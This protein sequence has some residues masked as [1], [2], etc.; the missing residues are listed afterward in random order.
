MYV[1]REGKAFFSHDTTIV[2]TSSLGGGE[3]CLLACFLSFPLL[4][5][6]RLLLLLGRRRV[7]SLTTDW[8]RSTCLSDSNSGRRE[9]NIHCIGSWRETRETRELTT[10]QSFLLLKTSN[11]SRKRKKEWE[12][13]EEEKEEATCSF[14]AFFLSLYVCLSISCV[15]CSGSKWG[16][17]K[18]EKRGFPIFPLMI[19]TKVFFPSKLKTV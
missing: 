14:F 4:F 1:R 15:S 5:C 11:M 10:N 2:P 12:K 17:R 18:V 13:D 16:V 6:K 9:K 7:V 3:E 8:L 19:R